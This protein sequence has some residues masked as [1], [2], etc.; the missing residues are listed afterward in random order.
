M[1]RRR[2]PLLKLR[3]HHF[4]SFQEFGIEVPAAETIILHQLEMEGDGGLDPFDD[5]FA[6]RTVHGADRLFPCPGYSDD[7]GD[8]TVVIRRD[9]IS[10]I[11][12]RINTDAMTSRLMQH[13]DPAR[14]GPEIIIGV[15]RVDTAFDGMALGFIVQ[16]ADGV[17][18]RYFDLFLD[19]VKINYFLCSYFFPS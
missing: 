5:I 15:F 3:L 6:Q 10:C 7:L 4:K 12:V 9:R 2:W 17:A 14:R 8:H 1:H 13:G 18:R 16:P 19:E 11:G